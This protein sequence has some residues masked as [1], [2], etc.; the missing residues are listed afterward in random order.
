RRMDRAAA[1]RRHGPPA[2]PHRQLL[3]GRR[4][5]AHLA[6]R[7]EPPRGLARGARALRLHGAPA[8]ARAPPGRR[9][10]AARL[11]RPPPRRPR[12]PHALI[13]GYAEVATICTR[14]PPSTGSTRTERWSRSSPAGSVRHARAPPTALAPTSPGRT[15]APSGTG[16]RGRARW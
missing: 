15:T 8:R 5:H 13:D 12:A 7:A 16:R 6:A 2:Q 3:R 9:A 4:A 1:T 11:D 14:R 10:R